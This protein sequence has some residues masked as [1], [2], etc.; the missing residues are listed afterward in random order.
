MK[1]QADSSNRVWKDFIYREERERLHSGE[2]REK[3]V[4]PWVRVGIG[5]NSLFLCVLPEGG[6]AFQMQMTIS[7]E[8]EVSP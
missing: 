1:A 8:A 5:F 2:C 4:V 7:W 6:D 3:P